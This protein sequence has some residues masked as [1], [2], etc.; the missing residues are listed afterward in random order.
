MYFLSGVD[1]PCFDLAIETQALIG[2][3][4]LTDDSGG[5]IARRFPQTMRNIFARQ[6]KLDAI[7]ADPANDRVGVGIVSVVMINRDPIE[8][9]A[10]I[11]LHALHCVAG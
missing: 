3:A 11:A 2:Q 9:D 4:S 10:Q 5:D 6:E 1:T 8:L 7:S